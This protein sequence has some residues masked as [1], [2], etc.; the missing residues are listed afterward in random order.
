MWFVFSAKIIHG[1]RR[2]GSHYLNVQGGQPTS[3]GPCVTVNR[4]SSQNFM[5][6]PRN[7]QKRCHN[8]K[9]NPLKGSKMVLDVVVSENMCVLISKLIMSINLGVWGGK[10]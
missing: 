2:F 3:L 1:I 10:V 6:G 9:K 7:K 4:G 5:R 8:E